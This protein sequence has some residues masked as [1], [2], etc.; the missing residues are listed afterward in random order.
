MLC[1]YNGKEKQLTY[2]VKFCQKIQ[3]CNK[4]KLLVGQKVILQIFF[5]NEY[6]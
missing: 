5:L 2:T 4:M 3:I 1:N 6:R